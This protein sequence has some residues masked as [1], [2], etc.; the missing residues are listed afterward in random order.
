M[1]PIDAIGVKSSGSVTERMTG[2]YGLMVVV[3]V[4]AVKYMETSYEVMRQ[5][6]NSERHSAIPGIAVLVLP[7]P[8]CAVT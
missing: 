7:A 3:A 1:S 8:V 5:R 2:R 4:F 6:L